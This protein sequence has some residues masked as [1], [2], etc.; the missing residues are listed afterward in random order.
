MSGDQVL[1]SI[2][3][4][5]S[6]FPTEP[7]ANPLRDWIES[8]QDIKRRIPADV[9]VLPAHGK[10][11]RG[12]HER[13]DQLIDE[14]MTR[15]DALLDCCSEPR[16]VVDTFPALYRAPISNENLMFATGEAIAHLHY[17]MNE[18]QVAVEQDADGVNWF[19][20]I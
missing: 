14:H 9:L 2:S 15:L 6:V 13:I 8:L 16:R 1:P 11:F 10:P 3:S 17:L 7:E 18:Q 20:R 19:R 5:V 12:A 4:N